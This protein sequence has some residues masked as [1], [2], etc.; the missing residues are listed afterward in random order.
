MQDAP[1]GRHEAQDLLESY[2]CWAETDETFIEDRPRRP[3]P[4]MRRYRLNPRLGSGWMDMCQAGSGIVIGRSSMSM[5]SPLRYEFE[6]GPDCAGFGLL[7]E[8][9]TELRLSHGTWRASAASGEVFLRAGASIGHGMACMGRA[10]TGI[11]IDLPQSMVHMLREEGVDL[12]R[13]GAQMLAPGSTGCA[14]RLRG[15]ALRLLA[16]EPQD[17]TIHRLTQEALAL[18]LITVVAELETAPARP[19]AGHPRWRAAL[20][21]AIDI[22]H[23][24]WDQPHTI[25]QLA[26]RVGMNECYLKSMFRERTGEGIAAYLRRLR[27]EQARMLIEAGRHTVQ[28]VAFMA[29]YANPSHFAE[30]FR[31]VHGVL[32]SQLHA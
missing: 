28:E 9:A 14:A 7:V 32:P 3:S 6:W 8:G 24:E 1:C 25:A 20:E 4:G 23:A 12:V 30:A 17:S 13:A 15:L 29:G 16:L 22:L 5:P 27:M 26:R 21:A 19:R 18:E 11:S 2:H 10:V 31:R